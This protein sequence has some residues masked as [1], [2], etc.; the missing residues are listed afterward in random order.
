MILFVSYRN[1]RRNLSQ[2]LL[3]AGG[4]CLAVFLVSATLTAVTALN[5][6]AVT[7]VR[8]FIGGDVM[9]ISGT[10]GLEVS[11]AGAFADTDE[12]RLFD[13]TEL[14]TSLAG[15]QVTENLL[16]P[17]YVHSG[18]ADGGRVVTLLGRSITGFPAVAPPLWKGRYLEPQ[19]EGLPRLVAPVADPMYR[20]ATGPIPARVPTVAGD[21]AGPDFSSG[22]DFS[23]D[24]VGLTKAPRGGSAAYAPIT[25]LQEA[26]RCDKVLWLG[27]S[28]QAGAG[29]DQL[30][31]RVK[32]AAPGFT[33][34]SVEDF[35]ALI[36]VEGAELQKSSATIITLVMG[37]GCL[38]VVN[39]LLLLMRLRRREVG[40]MKVL[41]FSP[42]A[43][44]IGFMVE[45]VAATTFGTLV[46][47]VAGCLAGS[48]MGGFG[49]S[50]GTLAYIVGLVVVV[51]IVSVAGP[52]FVASRHSAMEVMRNV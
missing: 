36:D 23:L 17:V 13:P 47:Y 24:I 8:E 19:D 7:P 42:T 5:R 16:L 27:V 45:G 10:L 49:F 33:V 51:T 30:V 1:L 14:K 25:F 34:V 48:V 35:L 6:V 43:I 2:Y 21:V 52:S 28:G 31:T 22:Q 40:L 41:G 4:V 12:L 44:G 18:A 9:V 38:A 20:A 32:E 11:S 37:V 50:L 39:T 26:S 3:A 29:L 46:G 15:L